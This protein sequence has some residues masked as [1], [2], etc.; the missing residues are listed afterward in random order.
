MYSKNINA[1]ESINTVV[2]VNKSSSK[3]GSVS[4]ANS[5]DAAI[6]E[7]LSHFLVMLAK[8]LLIVLIFIGLACLSLFWRKFNKQIGLF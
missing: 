4:S 6:E 2:R 1:S 5:V 3:L 7:F 8:W